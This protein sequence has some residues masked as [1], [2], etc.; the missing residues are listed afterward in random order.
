MPFSMLN[1]S[2]TTNRIQ[3]WSLKIFKIDTVM[4]MLAIFIKMVTI[5]LE[6]EKEIREARVSKKVKAITLAIHESI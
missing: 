3:Q 1:V 5:E 2:A 6:I 4:V